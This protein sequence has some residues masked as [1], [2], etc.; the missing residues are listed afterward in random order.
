MKSR[1]Q[2]RDFFITFRPQFIVNPTNECAKLFKPKNQSADNTDFNRDD[3]S[4]V[5]PSF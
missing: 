4:G 1:V 3:G 2:A 5:K